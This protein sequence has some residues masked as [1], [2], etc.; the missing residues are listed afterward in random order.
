MRAKFSVDFNFSIFKA[1]VESCLLSHFI[2]AYA[3]TS[4]SENFILA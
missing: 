1:E 4:N 2:V 3:I